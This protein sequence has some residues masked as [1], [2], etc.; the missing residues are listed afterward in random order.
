MVNNKSDDMDVWKNGIAAVKQ[1]IK[2]SKVLGYPIKNTPRLL[3]IKKIKE[4]ANDPAKILWKDVLYSL[5]GIISPINTINI[6]LE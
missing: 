5:F 1:A 4:L 3:I 6:R 2:P